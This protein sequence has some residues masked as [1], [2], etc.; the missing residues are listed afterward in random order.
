MALADIKI[1]TAKP[2]PIPIPIPIQ[3]DK[4]HYITESRSSYYTKVSA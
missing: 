2:I 3:D 4:F 1:K